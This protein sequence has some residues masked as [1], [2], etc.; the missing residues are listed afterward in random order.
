MEER[1]ETYT[2]T[3]SE[4]L[5]KNSFNNAYRLLEQYIT[6]PNDGNTEAR[7]QQMKKFLQSND[8]F[9]TNPDIQELLK[10]GNRRTKRT[11]RTMQ[12]IIRKSLIHRRR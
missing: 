3:I 7:K 9:K 2:K 10:G 4:S 12:R 8:K 11:K 1:Y 6:S 5:L